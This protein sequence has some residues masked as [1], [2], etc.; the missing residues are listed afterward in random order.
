MEFNTGKF[1]VLK[2]GRNNEL[3][4]DYNFLAPG[5]DQIT[6]DNASVRDLGI[7][8]NAEANFSDHIAKIYA[9][10][11]Q[12]AGLLLRTIQNRTPEHMH[13]IW[14]TYYLPILD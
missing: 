2:L 4:H 6:S 10:I 12:R 5:N 3:K 11:S 1:N 13:F 14:R 9:K 8:V 7:I